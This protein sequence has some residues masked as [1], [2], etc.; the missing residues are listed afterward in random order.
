[1]SKTNAPEKL[2]IENATIKYRNFS[3]KEGR[4]NAKGLRN[5]SVVL[6]KD[7]ADI[8]AK[9]GWNVRV[10]EPKDPEDSPIYLLQVAVRFDNIPSRDPKVV[11][12]TSNSKT[13]LNEEDV[14]MLDWVVIKNVDIIIRPYVWEKGGNSGIKAYLQSIYV[15]GEDDPFEEKYRNVPDSAASSLKD[16][17][18][19]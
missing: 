12:I 11:Y 19:D 8:L 17:A 16:N 1:M 15:T 9:E 14:S 7:L 6:D 10:S 18:E 13:K 3:G 2:K 4:Y 5:F